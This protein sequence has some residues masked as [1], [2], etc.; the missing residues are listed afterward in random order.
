MFVVLVRHQDADAAGPV[1]AGVAAG[2][3]EVVVKMLVLG[4][5]TGVFADPLFPHHAE[6]KWASGGHDRDV[7]KDPLPIRSGQGFDDP[8]EER[9]L[10]RRAHDVVADSGRDGAAEPGRVGEQRVE[11][12]LTA[13]VEIDV[14]AAVIGEDEVADGVGALDV[15]FVAVEGGE[16]PGVFF[17]DEGAGFGVGPEDIFVVWVEVDAGLLGFKPFVGDVGVDVGLVNDFGDDLRA[18]GDKG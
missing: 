5:S 3:D 6:E 13:V 15:V 9:V 12:A 16:E 10:R 2:V 8:Q 7:G 17:R 1:G 14:D 18:G 4:L 11:A